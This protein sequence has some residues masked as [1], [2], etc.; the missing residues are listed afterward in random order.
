MAQLK[1]IIINF[2]LYP[3][4]SEIARHLDALIGQEGCEL[5]AINSP[6]M[7]DEHWDDL[8][9]DVMDSERCLTI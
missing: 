8:L 6:D 7:L 3:E 9:R 2:G 5:R 1:T 4:S